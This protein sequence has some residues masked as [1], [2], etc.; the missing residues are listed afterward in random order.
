MNRPLQVILQRQRLA[1]SVIQ[2]AAL[3]SM[4]GPKVSIWGPRFAF[5]TPNRM[6]PSR[7][8]SSTPRMRHSKSR[9]F[10]ARSPQASVN[11]NVFAAYRTRTGAR[12]TWFGWGL[13]C[14]H[15]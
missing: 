10:E 9:M 1:S 5:P 8:V 11:T 15:G 13:R 3:S 2:G 7:I 14:V 12:E 4:G 6:Y